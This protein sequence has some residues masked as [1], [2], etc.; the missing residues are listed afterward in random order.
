MRFVRKVCHICGPFFNV[1]RHIS[2]S[3]EL[4]IKRKTPQAKA[5]HDHDY[6]LENPPSKSVNDILQEMKIK[7]TV[8]HDLAREGHITAQVVP[9]SESNIACWIRLLGFQ[10]LL[11]HYLHNYDEAC[12][13]L[14]LFKTMVVLFGDKDKTFTW[15]CF[16]FQLQV[17]KRG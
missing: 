3:N 9:I 1:V 13:I 4:E 15:F 8:K 14:L 10:G 17:Q 6:L 11:G 5:H 12:V 7:E 2:R 16:E